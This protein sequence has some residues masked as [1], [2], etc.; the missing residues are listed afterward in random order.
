MRIP[1]AKIEEIRSAADI[2]DVVGDY[3]RLKPSGSDYKGLCPFH[4]EK[5]PSF[6]V[7]PAKNLFYCFG[8]SKGGDLFSFV[9][10]MEGIGF[11]ES[12]RMLAERFGV[13]LPVEDGP[14]E[15]AGERESIYH[16]LRFAARFF[17]RQLTQ[18]EAGEPALRYLRGRGMTPKTIKR[19]GLGYAPDR[20]DALLE[21][22][23]KEHI[24]PELLEKAGLVIA[25]KSGEGHYDRYRGRVIFPLFS[26]VGKVLGFA[27]RILEADTDQPKYINSPETRVYHKSQVLYGLH[28]GKKTIRDKS[29]VGIVEGYT[30]VITMHHYGVHNVV[31]TCGTSLTEQHVE[32][33]GRYVDEAYFIYDA[34]SA[35]ER[36]T[37]RGADTAFRKGFEVNIIELPGGEDPDTFVAKEGPEGF[38]EYI[39]DY[40]QSLP[41]FKISLAK[42]KGSFDTPIRRGKTVDSIIRSISYIPDQFVREDYIKELSDLANTRDLILL[43]KLDK[44]LRELDRKEERTSRRVPRPPV[45]QDNPPAEVR[46]TSREMPAPREAVSTAPSDEEPSKRPLPQEE[47]LLRLMLEHGT[48]MVKLILGHMGMDEFTEG[49]PRQMVSVLLKMYRAGAVQPKKFLG[50]AEGKALQTLAASVMADKH[51]ASENWQRRGV[52]QPRF[53]ADS[54]A[55]ARSAMTQLKLRRVDQAIDRLKDEQFRLTGGTEAHRQTQQQLMDLHALR[56]QIERREYLNL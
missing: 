22:A 51:G 28:Q 38:H 35:G 49:P 54:Q 50:G 13:A 8:C 17:Y 16:A 43:K 45:P 37:L 52:R 32:L 4:D 10:E 11:T 47:I 53:N 56:K 46:E 27:G 18:T 39:K 21:A 26:H 29:A 20:W 42:R 6:H 25:R 48:P 23:A 44:A 1:E 3:V 34:D 41:E 7:D 24:A 5:T 9:E 2:V 12:V 15:D 19:F 30:D 31:A 14:S 40:H 36:A 33:L 55:A